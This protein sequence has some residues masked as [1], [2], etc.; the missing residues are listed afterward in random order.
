MSQ[1][2]TLTIFRYSGIKQ[3]VW[4]FWM[5]QFAHK[6][7]KQVSGCE[8]YKLMGSG[9]EGFDPRPD[10]STYALL[11]IWEDE[12]ATDAFFEKATLVKRYRKQTSEMAIIYLKNLKAHGSWSG[13][14]PFRKHPDPDPVNPKV[15]VITRAT[16]KKKYLR[17][18][19]RYV[20]RS[21]QPLQHA[22]GLLYTKGIG[23]WPVTQMATF[24]IWES[25]EDLKN[26]AYH[27]EGHRKAIQ[28]TRELGWYRE[29][30]F[31]RFQPYR[32]EG[33]LQG[34]TFEF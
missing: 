31:S 16:I 10:W 13:G 14:N 18:F 21:Q 15:A 32:F 27:S 12:A 19:W 8:F 26:F 1:I 28:Y 5:M 17:R 7:L 34:K 9:R 30:L 6:H 11:Q 2:S 33:S 3:R 20:P 4:A 29:E 22:G 24:S 25:E 23:E